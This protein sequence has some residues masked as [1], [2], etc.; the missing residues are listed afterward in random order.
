MAIPVAEPSLRI[1]GRGNP[2][3]GKEGASFKDGDNY[4]W[5]PEEEIQ[6][7]KRAGL[8]P[9]TKEEYERRNPGMLKA[10]AYAIGRGL[11]GGILG[12]ETMYPSSGAMEAR[13]QYPITSFVGEIVGMLT[14]GGVVAGAGSLAAKA[15]QK[16]AAHMASKQAIMSAK[17]ITTL[18][19]SAAEG[20]ATGAGTAI[21]KDLDAS[22]SAVA[23]GALED[24]VF[25]GLITAGGLGIGAAGKR[26]L[27]RA[28][29]DIGVHKI[30]KDEHAKLERKINDIGSIKDESGRPIKDVINNNIQIMNEAQRAGR[31][32][33][34]QMPIL[35]KSYRAAAENSERDLRILFKDDVF[36]PPEPISRSPAPL[37]TMATRVDTPSEISMKSGTKMYRGDPGSK[38]R[39]DTPDE[40]ASKAGTELGDLSSGLKAH[41]LGT[42]VPSQ[43]QRAISEFKKALAEDDYW[44]SPKGKAHWAILGKQQNQW[45]NFNIAKQG[46]IQK[47]K[48]AKGIT[49]KV[50]DENKRIASR[51]GLSGDDL[52]VILRGPEA[53]K[54]IESRI[55]KNQK[56][57][58]SSLSSPLNAVANQSLLERAAIGGILGGLG[59]AIGDGDYGFSYK[60]MLLGMGGK[61]A[62]KMLT[63]HKGYNAARKAVSAAKK[64]PIKA[65]RYSA[66]KLMSN[67][68][69]EEV[70]NSYDVKYP[71]RAAENAYQGLIAGGTSEKLALDV[72]DYQAKKLKLIALASQRMSRVPFSKLS[73]A[74]EDPSGIVKRLKKLE[75]TAEDILTL[76]WLYPERY[77]RLLLEVNDRTR[78][79]RN[80]TSKERNQFKIIHNIP[81]HDS[82]TGFMMEMEMLDKQKEQKSGGGNP[83]APDLKTNMNRIA[84][85]G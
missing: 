47:I 25:S 3:I 20:I 37:K 30:L 10:A 11:S 74:V 75:A 28:G 73:R 85:G 48:F 84:G 31:Q 66:L 22:L 69:L 64:T 45:Q 52:G 43:R 65:A 83:S 4:V 8:T 67:E 61:Y 80:L 1:P 23:K 14:P 2:Y 62:A 33:V 7:A 9:E 34:R 19:S 53:L 40:L 72:A 42:P 63:S 18:A 79:N 50:S 16:A 70:K 13:E 55:S 32:A 57:I 17:S 21:G 44:T 6:E 24:A 78:K 82:L 59:G 41:G 81:V 56:A 58:W 46:L 36:P 77:Q 68:E 60:A 15:T 5:V 27:R 39:L 26:L 29:V 12:A 49:Q 71:D 38:T 35:E 54:N 76:R 51:L